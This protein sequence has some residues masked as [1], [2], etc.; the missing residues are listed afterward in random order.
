MMSGFLHGQL[1]KYV[2][3]EIVKRLSLLNVPVT[4]I[5]L[6]TFQFS[7]FY[8]LIIVKDYLTWTAIQLHP[9]RYVSIPSLWVEADKTCSDWWV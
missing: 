5:S 6:D 1:Q 2:S 7:F 9:H 8:S 4:E 3:F